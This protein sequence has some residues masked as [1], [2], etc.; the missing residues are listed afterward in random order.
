MKKL[1]NL[2]IFY[3]PNYWLKHRKL[4]NLDFSQSSLFNRYYLSFYKKNNPINDRYIKSGPQKLVNNLLKSMKNRSD[5]VFNDKKFKNYYFCNFDS[6]NFDL[7]LETV[8]I[9]QNKVIV[10]PLYTNNDF[11]KLVDLIKSHNNLKILTA[12]ESSKKTMQEVANYNI[13]PDKIVVIPVGVKSEKEIFNDF[14]KERLIKNDCLVYFKGRENSELNFIID[15]LNSRN[16]KFEVFIYGKYNN[17]ELIDTARFSKFGLI[18]GRT[19]SQGIAINEIM[20]T[21]LPILVFNSTVNNYEGKVYKGT[22]VP[23]WS[24]DCGEL[25]EDLEDF[26]NQLKNF[27]NKVELNKYNSQKFVVDNFSNESMFSKLSSIF[28]N[29]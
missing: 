16:I 5:V 28:N 13:D 18:Y 7:V 9:D 20:S 17:S 10:G 25:A 21:G 24:N 23:Y 2:N 6:D 27:V 22:T 26:D 29:F 12:S 11:L 1:L 3:D 8:K 14:K 15:K 19:E 4:F